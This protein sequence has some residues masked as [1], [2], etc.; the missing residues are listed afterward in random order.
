M[1][2]AAGAGVGTVPGKGK[3]GGK[4]DSRMTTALGSLAEDTGR[5]NVRGLE[6]ERVLALAGGPA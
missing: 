1:L 5:I 6:V 4:S 3:G 2:M